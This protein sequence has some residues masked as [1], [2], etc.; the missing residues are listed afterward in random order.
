MTKKLSLELDSLSVDS[1]ETAAAAEDAGTVRAAEDESAAPEYYDCTC[2]YSCVC[3]T[4]YYWCGDGYHTLYSCNYT[5]NES[6]A[7]SRACTTS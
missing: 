2:A 3:K 6:C 7:V 4:A 1:F 5:S